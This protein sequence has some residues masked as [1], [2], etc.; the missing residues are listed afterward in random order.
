VDGTRRTQFFC[1]LELSQKVND[2][3]DVLDTKHLE[4][5]NEGHNKFWKAVLGR[6]TTAPVIDGSKPWVVSVTWGK[7][8]T[9]GENKVVKRFT[10]LS[11]AH[12]YLR[13]RVKDKLQKGYVYIHKKEPSTATEKPS[14]TY[15]ENTYEWDIL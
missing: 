10:T 5:T 6:E 11:A 15:A 1:L 3:L 13:G 12:S 9:Q 2:M 7:I 14:V 8:G 4:C